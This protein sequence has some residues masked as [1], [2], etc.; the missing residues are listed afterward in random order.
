ML[1]GDRAAGLRGGRRSTCTATFFT[2]I[3]APGVGTLQ[4]A[5]RRQ[6]DLRSGTTLL[7]RWDPVGFAVVAEGFGHNFQEHFS[8]VRNQ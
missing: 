2:A 6:I 7:L 5:C 1:A 4:I 3:P 8:C